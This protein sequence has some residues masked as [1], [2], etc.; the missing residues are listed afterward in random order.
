M[1]TREHDFLPFFKPKQKVMVYFPSTKVFFSLLLTYV[2]TLSAKI[3]K[4]STIEKKLERSK[5]GEN[6]GL[7][8]SK[9]DVWSVVALLEPTPKLMKEIECMCNQRQW[10]N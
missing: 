7:S 5:S 6:T 4:N 9:W 8:R 2:L 10:Y 3:V 1:Q